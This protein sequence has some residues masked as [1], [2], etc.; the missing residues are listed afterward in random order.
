MK[1]N[2]NSS[3]SK[4]LRRLH[5]EESAN[6]YH[7]ERS[8]YE[9]DENDMVSTAQ[10]KKFYPH[11]FLPIR[12]EEEKIE[13]ITNWDT[14]NMPDQIV[15]LEA[16]NIKKLSQLNQETSNVMEVKLAIGGCIRRLQSWHY[17]NDNSIEPNTS[18]TGV[19]RTEYVDFDR[20]KG[21]P[22]LYKYQRIHALV[23]KSLNNDS[24][25][26][27]TRLFL[28][29]CVWYHEERDLEREQKLRG[30]L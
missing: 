7:E 21:K 23:V 2:K 8:D 27:H 12:N 5:F 3:T 26:Y 24:L 18:G 19:G 28:S 29:D 14:N 25:H 13:Y 6:K 10:K 22:E 16:S 11:S 9:D 15:N 4:S 20:L 30:N 1:A 17:V